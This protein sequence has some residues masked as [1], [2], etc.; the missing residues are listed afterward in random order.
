MGDP[1]SAIAGAVSIVDV[2]VRS[3]NTLFDSVRYL[4]DAP[5]L[6]K[7]LRETVQS[8]RSTLQD[9]NALV[10]RYRQ[11]QILA[12]QLQLP[13]AV[14]HEILA[15]KKDL[16]VLL[17]LI[18]ATH[19]ARSIRTRLKWINNRREV[20]KMTANSYE[21]VISLSEQTERHHLNAKNEIQA[22]LGTLGAELQ[23]ALRTFGQQAQESLAEQG[24]LE[25]ILES[26][27][28]SQENHITIMD[29][30]RAVQSS[31]SDI[32]MRD[33]HVRTDTT[34]GIPKE[35]AVARVIR[36]ELR[37]VLKPTVEQ[38]LKTFKADTDDQS[39]SIL[40][41]IDEL[42]EHFG[43]DLCDTSHSYSSSA[44]NSKHDAAFNQKFIYHDTEAIEL[45]EPGKMGYESSMVLERPNGFP[46]RRSKHWRQ[47]HTIKWAIGT[48]WVSVSSTHTISGVS[49]AGETQP[50]TEYRIEIEFQPAQFLITLRGLT[51]S[52]AHTQD[53]RGYYQVYPLLAT[54]AIVPNDADVMMFAKKNDVAGL[55]YL[56]ER[57]LAAPSDRDETG[58][59]PLLVAAV[60]G[61]L[62]TCQFLLAMGADPLARHE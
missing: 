41:N 19:S 49:Y 11:S 17:S 30:I 9:L 56:F 14:S 5:E 8:I 2:A 36:A 16:D 34:I 44:S 10:A 60:N 48:L 55:Q 27:R 43:Q 47:S 52:L 4:K 15:I 32:S 33:D 39:R 7:E 35:A 18:P 42:A 20:E 57:R 46:V 51:L 54:F 38:C 31:L 24:Y 13:N 40:K 12:V 58:A 59:T 22:D 26:Q 61:A 62:D 53:Q 28:L 6:T 29:E 37:R 25:R 23:D 21:T 1:F 3:C 50:Q 45:L